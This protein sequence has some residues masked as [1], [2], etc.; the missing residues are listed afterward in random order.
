MT[1]GPLRIQRQNS[2]MP[3]IFNILRQNATVSCD[4]YY[5]L[6]DSSNFHRTLENGLPFCHSGLQLSTVKLRFKM[7]LFVG[8]HQV[9]Q[10][11]TDLA[12][13]PDKQSLIPEAYMV[14]GENRHLE[15]GSCPLTSTHVLLCQSLP[16]QINEINAI[17]IARLNV[18]KKNL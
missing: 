14:E 12:T 6:I 7:Y 8:G 13:K 2:A 11:V 5:G 1:K 15:P 18:K 16:L 9:G 17:K 10:Q 4:T 3:P